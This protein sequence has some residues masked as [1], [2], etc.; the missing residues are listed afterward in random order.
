MVNIDELSIDGIP[1]GSHEDFTGGT[2]RVGE[3]D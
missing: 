3:D 1:L 2:S